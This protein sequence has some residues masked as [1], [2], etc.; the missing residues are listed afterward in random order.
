MK[1][2]HLIDKKS[3]GGNGTAPPLVAWQPVVGSYMAVVAASSYS[4]RIYDRHGELVDVINLTSSCAALEWSPDGSCLAILQAQASAILLW[5]AQARSEVAIE[6]NLRGFTCLAW[7]RSGNMIAAG[8]SK[9]NL[10]IHTLS[11]GSSGPSPGRSIPVLGKHNRAITFAAW[12]RHDTVICLSEDKSFSVSTPDGDAVYQQALRAAPSATACA[13]FAMRLDGKTH[14]VLATALDGGK[15]LYMHSVTQ[16][17]AT[18]PIEL[19]LQPKYG[20]ITGVWPFPLSAAAGGNAPSGRSGS[21]ASLDAGPVDGLAVACANGY[22]VA[23]SLDEADLGAERAVGRPFKPTVTAKNGSTATAGGL[24]AAATAAQ[25]LRRSGS[26]VLVGS[27][28][29]LPLAGA[30]TAPVVAA[31]AQDMTTLAV[32]C[33][34]QVKVIDLRGD[35][36]DVVH[37][38]VVDDAAAGRAGEMSSS[39][40]SL[41]ADPNGVIE[42]TVWSMDG[43]F[44]TV[45]KGGDVCS[46]VSS[47]STLA[48]SNGT[49][50]AFL[51]GLTEVTVGSLGK[52]HLSAEP[53]LLSLSKSQISFAIQK[54][55][56]AYSLDTLV[57]TA[58]FDVPDPILGIECND[59]IACVQ[60][61]K[62]TLLYSLKAPKEKPV[63]LE[64]A[65]LIAIH[66]QFVVLAVPGAIRHYDLTGQLLSELNF[67]R[68]VKKLVPSR[69]TANAILVSE[70]ENLLYTAARNQTVPLPGLGGAY[71]WD[72][73]WPNLLYTWNDSTLTTLAYLPY[74][75]AGPPTVVEVCM[76]ALPTNWT[77][78]HIS[79]GQVTCVATGQVHA[80]SAL[81][82]SLQALYYAGDTPKLLRAIAAMRRV[83]GN[84]VLP[85]GTNDAGAKQVSD[86][87]ARQAAQLVDQCLQALDLTT[88]ALIYQQL[89]DAAKAESLLGLAGIRSATAAGD[90]ELN[91]LR[92]HVLTWLGDYTGAQEMYLAS[93]RAVLALHLRKDLLQWEQ[94]LSLAAKIAP[95]E[96]PLVCREYARQLEA[97]GR[98]ADA[99]VMYARSLESAGARVGTDA[100][101]TLLADLGLR[102]C[103]HGVARMKLRMGDFKAIRTILEFNDRKLFA[104]AAGILEELK[105]WHE[106]GAFYEKAAMFE[107]AAACFLKD[108]N[109]GKLQPIIKHVQTPTYLSEYGRL[110]E[111]Q[112]RPEEALAAYERAN[113]AASQT[114]VFLAL[115]R[116]DEAVAV[117]RASRSRDAAKQV[118]EYLARLGDAKT[119]LEFYLLADMKSEAYAR[120]KDAGLLGE[121]VDLLG[122]DATADERLAAATHYEQKRDSFRAGKYYLKA[123]QFEAA[124]AH[125]LRSGTRAALDLAIETVGQAKNDVLTH[126]LIAYL[127]SGGMAPGGLATV[128][129]PGD[130]VGG[131][132]GDG[133]G[134]APIRDPRYIFKLYMSLEQFR[135]AA[136]IAVIIAREEWVAGNYRAARD[137]LFE[138]QRQLVAGKHHVPAQMRHM[139][140]LLHSYILVKVLVRQDDHL[141]G[142]RM[143]ARVSRNI[144]Q[145]PAHVVPILTSTVLECL[146]SGL[147]GS[148]IEF[149]SLLMRPEYRTK[150]DAKYKKKIESVVRK[151]QDEDRD[152]PE[153]QSKCCYCGHLMNVTDMDCS[154]CKNTLP[155]CLASG[156]HMTLEAWSQCPSCQSPALLPAIMALAEKGVECP[157]CNQPLDASKIVPVSDARSALLDWQGVSAHDQEEPA[158]ASAANGLIG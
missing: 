147:K 1:R 150:L 5:R 120:A 13:V 49:V 47:V 78:L 148:A 70:P 81:D 143:L 101:E 59:H 10:L 92:G 77:P 157:M 158:G 50:T 65:T 95:R 111:A 76:A 20:A 16:P 73:V 126:E 55:V 136:R 83:S 46:F 52:I 2:A 89:G 74:T 137:V 117:V 131:T 125:L 62:G 72:A 79:E 106:A 24:A 12:T 133:S 26:N 112:Q 113:D 6:S 80:F 129:P 57:L 27:N 39:I 109:L 33:G 43:K 17:A 32:A 88:P 96:E 9:G 54:Q 152:P 104:D 154:E 124:L 134:P 38:L 142:A 75:L 45:C 29:A 19:A 3:L 122:S 118:A 71:L 128:V 105:E 15:A 91:V 99:G 153:P 61:P 103:L 130:N 63:H 100:L 149:A 14:T 132:G 145:F 31:L 68:P 119:V 34:A 23:L 123:H 11:H 67:A 69:Q 156:Y 155:F 87:D 84:G 44:L 53:Q 58:T 28:S 107:K 66:P 40:P 146:R 144:S 140:L 98:F 151:Q 93:S 86:M 7:S 42:R 102:E 139:L 60:T 116:I 115:S 141:G 97:D 110:L 56:V 8:T 138:T 127:M 18:P 25:G 82:A 36:R 121:Y 35:L 4:L 21:S 51:S 108:K 94:A 114:R 37:S 48:A 90:E 135:E 41:L 85:K 30:A 22:I 64:R